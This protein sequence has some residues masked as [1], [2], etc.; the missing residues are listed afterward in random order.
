MEKT[1]YKETKD[2]TYKA[3]CKKT[4]KEFSNYANKNN[5]LIEYITETYPDVIIP[6]EYNR[7]MYR[8]KHGIF[9]YENYF[10]IIQVPKEKITKTVKST[11][12]TDEDKEQIIELYTSKKISGKI[13]LARMF[14]VDIK[15]INQTLNEYN[16]EEK[17]AT[18]IKDSYIYEKYADDENYT[19]KAICK[20]TG[21]EFSDY[22]N[23]HGY[24]WKHIEKTYPN[25]K[26]DTLYAE[27]KEYKETGM[28]WFEK[29]FDIVKVNK[30]KPETK[31]CPYCVWETIDLENKSGWFEM[32]LKQVHSIDAEKHLE[33][34]PED[35]GYFK[36]L[37]AKN[38]R[39]EEFNDEKNYVT[40]EICGEKFKALQSHI[41]AIH[42][43]TTE[44]YKKKYNTSS[45]ISK[46]KYDEFRLNSEKGNLVVSK[47]R[48]VSKPEKE[49][50]KFL[51][52]N[53]VKF[54]P[55][56]QILIGKELDIL[57]EDKKIAIEFNGLKWHSEWFGKKDRNYHLNKT[58]ECEKKGY[59]LIHIFEDEFVNS[60]EL[61]YSKLKHILSIDENLPK[62]PARKCV[63]KNIYKDDE[64][65]FLEKYHIQGV[66]CSSVSLGAYYE[67][68]LVAV[69]TFKEL[70]KDSGEYDLTRFASNINYICQGVGG[71]L[72][73]RFIKNYNPK[74]VV[75]FADR[76][77]TD[78]N[79]NIYL[80]M[81]FKLESISKPEYRYYNE[82]IEK[83]RRFHKFGFRKNILMK[84]YGKDY[85]LDLSMTETEM[86][87]I[88]G[89]DRIWD[90]GL[91]KYKL[92]F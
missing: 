41:E 85:N 75:S 73:S 59:R 69:M 77:W 55:N 37:L 56:R 79:D 91:L 61:V 24:L 33:S 78:M 11:T 46:A 53:N 82:K 12:L 44:E 92:T 10:D 90:C 89:Y 40:C 84:K 67:D 70:F 76:R 48:F 72:F 14:H 29:Y 80:K 38:T 19:Y 34:Y 66:G 54:S 74:S 58:E 7:C 63:V 51:T 64:K 39:E 5:T 20:K 27:K 15:K 22:A 81:G 65:T 21:E 26:R 3:V 52:E 6:T 23:A 9:W 32:H 4:G 87:K 28:Y 18:S 47:K 43:I 1:H 57:I 8:G 13:T 83:F 60:K 17:K 2:Y 42:N 86:V 25:P 31:K 45:I 62:I 50:Q 30:I 35:K 49:I 36:T 71:K 16:I 68:E 88:L